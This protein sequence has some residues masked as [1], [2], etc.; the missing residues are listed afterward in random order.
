MVQPL[1]IMGSAVI[2]NETLKVDGLNFT[3]IE[4][5]NK[6]Y[7][8][9]SEALVVKDTS[10]LVKIYYDSPSINSALRGAI[11]SID[12]YQVRSTSD[13]SKA[14]STKQPGD[15][16]LLTTRYTENNAYVNKEYDLVL[17]SDYANASRPVLGIASIPVKSMG[18]RGFIYR[19]MNNFKDASVYYEPKANEAA[20]IFFYNLIWW[21]FLINLSVAIANM[22]PFAIFDGG[23]FLYLT[24]LIITRK[25]KWAKAAFKYANY[26]L[27]AVVVLMM[28]LWAK[29]LFF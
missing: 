18:F 10:T 15:N 2:M 13:I 17:G 14:L 4:L 21:I 23:R 26:L 19:M 25:E 24:I 29:G 5:E 3:K 1:S 12:N 8:I 16:V 22:L 28:L 7:F 6:S 11:T 20:T 27:L 9:P